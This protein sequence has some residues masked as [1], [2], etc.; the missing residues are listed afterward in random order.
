MNEVDAM[1]ALTGI[2]A[3]QLSRIIGLP[4]APSLVDVCPS[5]DGDLQRRLLPTAR[6]LKA[7]N[8]SR[9]AHD[10]SGRR[11]VVYCRD[12]GGVSQGTAAWL[13]HAG[14]DA[15][16]LEGGVEAWRQAEQPCLRTHRIPD[17]DEAGRTTWVTR[18]RPKIVRIACPW[19]IRRFIDPTAIFLYVAASEVAAVAARFGA[20]PFDTGDGL[21]ND[22]GEACTFDVMI[23]EFNLKTEPLLRMAK[24]IRGADTGRPELTPQSGG[25]LA[26][27]L[28]YSRML[29]DDLAQLDATMPVYDALY[30][31]CRDGT[32]E[33]HG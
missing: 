31:W 8:V 17:R 3:A 26:I 32:E 13:R 16:T 1:P 18:T 15:Q 19:L 23:E 14:I 2:S 4:D 12:G 28:G 29:R 5:D 22:R 25:L 27:S 21:W 9:W 24:I 33:T 11:V 30:R 20:T 6:P 7:E 10:F